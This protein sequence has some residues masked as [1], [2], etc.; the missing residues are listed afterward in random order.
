MKL[1]LSTL[2]IVS[3]SVYSLSIFVA[4]TWDYVQL[5]RFC[6][7]VLDGN[8]EG[9]CALRGGLIGHWP[10]QI[11]DFRVLGVFEPVQNLIVDFSVAEQNS[12][13]SGAGFQRRVARE[14]QMQHMLAGEMLHDFRRGDE[15]RIF[16]Q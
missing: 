5:F 16:R 7:A 11:A 3:S 4:V 14:A 2:L 15:S 12:D 8:F 13:G 6:S 10:E 9:W 1:L